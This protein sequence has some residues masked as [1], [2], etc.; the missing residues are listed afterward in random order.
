MLKKMTGSRRWLVVPVALVAAAGFATESGAVSAASRS[1]VDHTCARLE[2]Q[3]TRELTALAGAKPGSRRQA[4][5]QF[6]VNK[7]ENMEASNGC[8]A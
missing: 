4:I 2:N 8:G 5:L 1:H 6:D 7:T 3:E